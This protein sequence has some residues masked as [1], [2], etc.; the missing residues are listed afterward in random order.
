MVESRIL[1]CGRRRVV[2]F[3]RVGCNNARPFERAERLAGGD[4]N[5]PGLFVDFFGGV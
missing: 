2:A 1:R 3:S 5:R 4:G